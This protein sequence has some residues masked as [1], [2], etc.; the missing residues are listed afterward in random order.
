[1][2]YD[3][4]DFLIRILDKM[5]DTYV[6]LLKEISNI[7]SKIEDVKSEVL[8]I[9]TDIETLAS[10]VQSLRNELSDLR[11]KFDK[12]VSEVEA[13]IRKVE[14]SLRNELS[15]LWDKFDK[16]VSKVEAEIRKVEGRIEKAEKNINNHLE[17]QDEVLRTHG[18]ALLNQAISQVVSVIKLNYGKSVALTLA[19]TSKSPLVIIESGK[20]VLILSIVERFHVDIKS[21]L[22]E[23]SQQIEIYTGKK[24]TYKILTLETAGTNR[25]ETEAIPVWAFVAEG[26]AF[27]A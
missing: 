9:S 10:R 5:K 22:E 24:T 17:K 27:R 25:K 23:L 15:D 13:E 12:R 1:M 8:S 4:N 11:D 18:E 14:E 19:Q 20:S 3:E 2:T 16:R 7:R 26:E 6:L 21:M